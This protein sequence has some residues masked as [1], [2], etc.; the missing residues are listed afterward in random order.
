M[1]SKANK[2][3]K[4]AG[5]NLTFCKYYALVH[6]REKNKIKKIKKHLRKFEGDKVAWNTLKVLQVMF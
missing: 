2:Q 1:A 4:K 6:R 5:R 3:S